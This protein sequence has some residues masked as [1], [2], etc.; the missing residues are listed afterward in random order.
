MDQFA[1]TLQDM[2]MDQDQFARL[3]KLLLTQ[4][5]IGTIPVSLD[6]VQITQITRNDRHRVKCLFLIGC[7]DHVLP[8][9]P[10]SMGLLN[11]EDRSQL[12]DCGIELAPSGLDLLDI[13]LQNLY[14]A[15]AQPTDQ[16]CISWPVA[17]LAGNALRPSFVLGRIRT[18]VPGITE[19]VE[20]G[21]NSYRLS[22]PIP[23]LEMVGDHRGSSLWQYFA[24]NEGYSAQLAAMERAAGMSRGKLSR[25]AV[26]SL[27]GCHYRMSASRIEKIKSCHFAYFMQYGLKAKERSSAGFDAIQIGTFLHYVLEHVTRTAMERGGFQ[28][29]S[30]EELRLLVH[31]VIQTYMDTVIPEFE[32]KSARFQYLFHRLQKTAVTI[33]ENIARE[34][35]SSD[36]VP[37][38]FVLDF[39]EQGDLPGISIS[40]GDTALTLSGKVDRV[41]G[42][43]KD[44]KL[45]LR[46]V[47][48]KSGKKSFE[49]SDVYHGLNIQMLLYLFALER[50]G[51]QLSGGKEIVPAG[52]LY[53]PARDVL[54]KAPRGTDEAQLREAMDTELRRSGLVLSQP[55]VIEAMEHGA[56]EQPKFL[57][58]KIGRDG[59]ITKG[60]ATAEELGKLSR[61]LNKILEEILGELSDGNIS[62]DPCGR[63]END[64]ACIYCEFASAC[65]FMEV[66]EED[67]MEW[68]RSVKPEEF[69]KSINEAIGEGENA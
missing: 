49:L 60:I 41:D 53:L 45:Y 13:E 42:W 10:S 51:K 26:E 47:D 63:A 50:E 16:L 7:N 8:S 52:V 57:P 28:N 22:A 68:I 36:F 44:D 37:L 30:T 67:G 56:M 69:W 24:E 31:A 54:L 9:V 34:L 12:L 48:Y 38:Y 65:H 20:Q 29:L 61:Y 1:D 64:N 55:D 15:L 18:L 33:V 62:A 35:E 11:R 25:H 32:E 2:P 58:L 14:A 6:Q 23:A 59:S 19:Q 4:Y 39:G 66:D 5:D 3:M 27:Y 46:V 43:V 40:A 21:D 17:D